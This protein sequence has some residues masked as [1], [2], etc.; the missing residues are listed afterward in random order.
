M[1]ASFAPSL[2]AAALCLA[3]P[4]LNAIAQT[5]SSVAPPVPT[6]FPV[7]FVHTIDS[8]RAK[9]GDVVVAKTMEAVMLPD[10]ELRKGAVVTGHIVEARPFHFDQTPYAVQQPS[11]ISIHFDKVTDGSRNIPLD[12]AVRA[13]ANRN[14]AYEASRPHSY[15]DTDHLGTMVLVGGDHYSPIGKQVMSPDDED[16]VGYIHKQGPY[17][18]LLPASSFSRF[19]SLQCDGSQTEQ[20][21]GVFSADACGAYGFGSVAVT[22]DQIGDLRLESQHSTVKVYSGSAAL[23][24]EVG[25]R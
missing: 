10:G 20:A 4:A 15:D 7:V 6:T 11:Y 18:H 13:L 24:E 3:L 14:E 17:A 21:I 1:R 12:V 23:L 9:P 8:A 19:G 5:T 22:E 16:I 25:A 2:C